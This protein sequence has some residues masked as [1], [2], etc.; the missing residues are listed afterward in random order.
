MPQG[1]QKW[2]NS[3][4]GYGIL[5]HPLLTKLPFFLRQC[6]KRMVSVLMTSLNLKE[7]NQPPNSCAPVSSPYLSR[8]TG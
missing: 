8:K 2:M 7:E 6:E 1:L 3:S 4:K 5:S